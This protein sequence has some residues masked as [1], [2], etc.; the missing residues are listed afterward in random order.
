M[1]TK[2]SQNGK[3]N[4]NNSC[5]VI[6]LASLVCPYLVYWLSSGHTN[7]ALCPHRRQCNSSSLPRSLVN[8]LTQ[9]FVHVAVIIIVRPYLVHLFSSG[10]TNTALCHHRRHYHSS[11]LPRSLVLK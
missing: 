3:D 5:Q 8:I 11:S 2:R 1:I 6:R 10:H 4:Y 9:L 7:I